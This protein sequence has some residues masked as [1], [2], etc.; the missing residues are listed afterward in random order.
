MARPV[1]MRWAAVSGRRLLSPYARKAQ[2]G[3]SRYPN[4]LPS[5]AMTAATWITMFLV[6][7]FIWGGFLWVLRMAVRKEAEKMD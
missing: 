3:W 5:H 7:G 2:V 4:L 1:G 6:L